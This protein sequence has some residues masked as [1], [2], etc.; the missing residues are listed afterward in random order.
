[1]PQ[2]DAHSVKQTV[3]TSWKMLIGIKDSFSSLKWETKFLCI[4]SL[5]WGVPGSMTAQFL[6]LYMTELG[7]TPT[8]IGSFSTITLLASALFLPIAGYLADTYGRKWVMICFDG[9]RIGTDL[10]QAWAGFTG[11]WRFFFLSSFFQGL[12][13]IGG[14]FFNLMTM[15]SV[16]PAQRSHAFIAFR[17]SWI[18]PTIFMPSLGYV[19][20][21]SFGL[22]YGIRILLIISAV[23]VITASFLRIHYLKDPYKSSK[24]D[25]G[26]GGGLTFGRIRNAGSEELDAI[27]WLGRNSNVVKV[28]LFMITETFALNV[29]TRYTT[30]YIT[31]YLCLD[32][33]VLAIL[34]AISTTVTLAMMLF[35]ATPYLAH[36]GEKLR[37]TILITSIIA[38][39]S[40]ILFLLAT[41]L[42]DLTVS[43]SLHNVGSSIYDPAANALWTNIIPRERR[44]RIFALSTLIKNIVI[45]PAPVL[46][47]YVFE[48]IDPRGPF[49]ILV[50]LECL[51]VVAIASAKEPRNQEI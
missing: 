26:Y 51:A 48:W 43:Q 34:P 40:S 38:P 47:G 13:N 32:P 37:R 45:L 19:V 18:I 28:W 41:N 3:F 6:S 4:T 11:D 31:T 14:T 9:C 22:V 7:A 44:G 16:P 49:F 21:S 1:M 24:R 39:T 20:V 12:Q 50:A 25:P 33:V 5:F 36:R 46:G 15:E 29:T 2:E 27:K 42:L 23:S 10:I 30:L 35:V 17:L 8:N